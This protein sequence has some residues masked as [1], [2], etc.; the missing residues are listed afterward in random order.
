M[1]ADW[2]TGLVCGLIAAWF[3]LRAPSRRV[4]DEMFGPTGPL[5][6]EPQPG[7]TPPKPTP[8]P[9]RERHDRI[10]SPVV[11]GQVVDYCAERNKGVFVL[12]ETALCQIP[13][14]EARH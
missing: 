3:F 10:L 7:Q 14:P 13:P 2:W 12:S 8:P 5:T 11:S 9:L 6:T 1:T 4:T